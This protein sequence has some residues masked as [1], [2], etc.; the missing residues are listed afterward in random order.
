MS[1]MRNLDAFTARV[2]IEGTT[3]CGEV[4][5]ITL[6]VDFIYLQGNSKKSAK[7]AAAQSAVEALYGAQ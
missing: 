6:T 4:K 1:S 5:T 7:K 3:Y 2:I